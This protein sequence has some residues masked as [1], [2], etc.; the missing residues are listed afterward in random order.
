[1]ISIS[2][3]RKGIRKTTLS[4]IKQRTAP[5]LKQQHEIGAYFSVAVRWNPRPKLKENKNT[6]NNKHLKDYIYLHR[7]LPEK[8]SL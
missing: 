2:K 7:P 6:K 1:M 8:I 3:T 4:S 5:Y